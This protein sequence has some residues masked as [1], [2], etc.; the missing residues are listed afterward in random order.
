MFTRDVAVL[1][2]DTVGLRDLY[3]S[4]VVIINKNLGR[5]TA[6]SILCINQN[7]LAFCLR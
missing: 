1:C 7:G 3:Y 2:C 6:K 4:M 5:F